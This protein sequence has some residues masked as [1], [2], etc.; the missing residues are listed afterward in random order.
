MALLLLNILEGFDHTKLEPLGAQ[1]FHLQAEAMKLAFRERD[2]HLAD[3]AHVDVP[4]A[5]LLDKGFAAEL[6]E[7]IDQLRRDLGA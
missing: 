7:S 6:R 3:P 5:R 1:R 2:R 4:T